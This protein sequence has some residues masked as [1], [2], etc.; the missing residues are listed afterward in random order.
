M[1]VKTT[2][3]PF[4]KADAKRMA[5]RAAARAELMQ[6]VAEGDTIFTVC[7]LISRSGVTAW[8]N[9]YV[10][11]KQDGPKLIR[12][13][14]D[15]CALCD[16]TYCADYDGIKTRGFG[17]RPRLLVESLSAALFG[18]PDALDFQAL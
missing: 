13:T 14:S 6:H 11:S 16:F 7:N 9:L 3:V 12:L 8:H 5:T 2:N 1:G 10:L 15:V 4:A 17:P 18:K